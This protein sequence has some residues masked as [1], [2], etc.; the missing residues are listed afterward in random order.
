MGK[1]LC[2][3]P[4]GHTTVLPKVELSAIYRR[5]LI[6]RV[7][8]AQCLDHAPHPPHLHTAAEAGASRAVSRRC[9]SI[10]ILQAVCGAPQHHGA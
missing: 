5:A 7:Q 9:A 8:A 6:S 4:M 1:T 2:L 10:Y 3:N